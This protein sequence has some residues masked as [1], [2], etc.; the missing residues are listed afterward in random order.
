MRSSCVLAVVLVACAHNV[1]QDAATGVDGRIK[2][3]TPIVLAAGEA[4]AKGIVTYPGGDRVD[5]KQIQLPEGKRGTL[6]MRLTWQAPRPGLQVAFDVFDQWNTPVPIVNATHHRRGHTRTATI[7]H[8]KG[9][10]FVR[11]YAPTRGDAGAY[12]LALSFAEDKGPIIADPRTV[13]VDE[14]P[15]LPAIPPPACETFDVAD[16]TCQ[17]VCPPTGAPAGWPA[18]AKPGATP[19]T[20]PPP[21]VVTAP[22]PVAVAPIVARI[23]K[24]EVVSD[25]VIITI[26]AGSERGVDRTWKGEVLR[27]DTTT[28]L[29]GGA[30]SIIRVSKLQTV[31]KVKL[32]TDLLT[33]NPQV[34][35][36][37]P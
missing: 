23:I 2:G 20:P 29:A 10:Y 27:V 18:C 19:A 7:D 25:G 1:P 34:R 36:G 35:L 14:P 33:Q 31:A 3:A 26:S 32:T 24:V 12:K 13:P 22:P 30:I 15:K 5:W 9:T 16:P 17:T 37:P 21:P 11:V 4:K 6:D 8:A 28:P